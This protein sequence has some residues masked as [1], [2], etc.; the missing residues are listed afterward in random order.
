MKRKNPTG[1]SIFFHK[2]SFL[3]ILGLFCFTSG[4]VFAGFM[5]LAPLRKST[6]THLPNSPNSIA[7]VIPAT[8]DRP[9]NI[10]ILGID[11]SGHP[12]QGKFTPAEALSGNSDTMLLVHLIP[13]TH[14]INVLSIPRD[15]LVHSLG[16]E[17][18]KIN[19]ANMRGG[20]KLAAS[21]VSQLLENTPVD[22][23]LRVDTEGF[24]S[25]IDALGGLEVNIPKPMKYIDK[26]QHLF[27]Q[28]DQGRQKLDGEHLQ[29]YVRFRHDAL[30]DIGRVQ[31]QQAV[32]KELLRKLI[33]PETL[34]KIPK[35]IEVFK[36][37][38]DT[39]FS[40]A[41]ILGVAQTVV[42][43]KQNKLHLV[44]LPGR[45]SRKEEYKLSYWIA[46][47]QATKK[48]VTRYFNQRQLTS[49]ADNP[50]LDDPKAIRISVVSATQNRQSISHVANILLKHGFRHVS[51]LDYKIDAIAEDPQNTQIIAQHANPEAADA[52]S[53]ALG[54]GKV[55]VSSVGDISSDV[56]VVV[57]QDFQ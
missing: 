50:T 11:N 35:I 56:T 10:M 1:K 41:E 36:D 38:V 27:I 29:E 53:S 54:L 16:V 7:G 44:M 57:G 24:S 31:R 34:A 48:I 26:S 30:G 51:A 40:V 39:D 18:D 22:R 6:T 8:L 43:S 13:N 46:D 42:N 17:V 23:Y 55:Q 3:G 52:V 12:H 37:N 4:A 47:P 28:F 49:V 14:E 19:D 20:A 5:S 2:L 9:I 33:S 15:T 25:L 32:L 21:A 45:F